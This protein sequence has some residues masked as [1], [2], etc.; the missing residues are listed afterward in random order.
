M[1]RWDHGFCDIRSGFV[2]MDEPPPSYHRS[3]EPVLAK[4]R[5]RSTTIVVAKL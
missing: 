5:I 4:A 2:V 1:A 3:E